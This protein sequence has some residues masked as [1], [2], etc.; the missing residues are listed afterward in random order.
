M[1]ERSAGERKK[2]LRRGRASEYLAA[3]ALM[4]RGYRILAMNYRVKG[5]VFDIL[6]RCVVLVIFI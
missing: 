6:V 2:A 4:L 3:F 1:R 5:G